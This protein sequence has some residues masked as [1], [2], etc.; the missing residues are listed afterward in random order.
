MLVCLLVKE[1]PDCRP[2]LQFHIHSYVLGGNVTVIKKM[3]L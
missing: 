2:Q 3:A 1:F